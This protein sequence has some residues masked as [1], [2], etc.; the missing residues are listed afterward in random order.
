MEDFAMTNESPDSATDGS[1]CNFEAADKSTF[2]LIEKNRISNSLD[3]KNL[4]HHCGECKKHIKFAYDLFE[5]ECFPKPKRR[6]C[7][8]ICLDSY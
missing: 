3:L 2:D 6:A 1:V 4:A 8:F 5:V 7:Y